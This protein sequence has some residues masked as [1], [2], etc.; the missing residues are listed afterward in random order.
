[1]QILVHQVMYGKM[2]SGQKWQN[3]PSKFIPSLKVSFEGM[4][5]TVTC[6]IQTGS[7]TWKPR[8]GLDWWKIAICHIPASNQQLLKKTLLTGKKN[9]KFPEILAQTSSDENIGLTDSQIQ[10]AH[11]FQKVEHLILDGDLI[12]PAHKFGEWSKSN[13]HAWDSITKKSS[14][15]RGTCNFLFRAL[16]FRF[17]AKKK[18]HFGHPVGLLDVKC[19]GT[20]KNHFE[21]RAQN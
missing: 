13:V 14:L 3:L 1:M 9:R 7:V 17:R 8:E 16:H 19:K 4:N 21:P 6:Q 15:C 2:R 18:K 10:P 20:F 11:T 12:V 5:S